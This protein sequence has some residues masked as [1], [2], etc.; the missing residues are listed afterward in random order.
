MEMKLPGKNPHD[1]E[2]THE[3]K[4]EKNNLLKKELIIIIRN[5]CL[6]VF[7]AKRLVLTGN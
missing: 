1:Q 4:L 5:Y 7:S 2:G 3:D 6:Q